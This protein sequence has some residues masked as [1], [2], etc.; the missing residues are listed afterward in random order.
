MFKC[1]LNEE[2]RVCLVYHSCEIET[3]RAVSL[4]VRGAFLTPWGLSS[5][6]RFA[7]SAIFH[8]LKLRC[9]EMSPVPVTALLVPYTVTP[10]RPVH[11]TRCIYHKALR[12]KLSAIPLPL[13]RSLSW[14]AH[15]AL[16]AIF[17][18]VQLRY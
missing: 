3:A 7:L 12:A 4:S 18:S 9:E 8:A 10:V 13:T 5:A 2:R 15:L 6:L 16:A 17:H 1:R 14:A 11:Y